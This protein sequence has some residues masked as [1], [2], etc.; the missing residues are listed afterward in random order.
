M[1]LQVRVCDVCGEVTRRTRRYEINREGDNLAVIV[2][3]CSRHASPLEAF[4]TRKDGEDEK[5]GAAATPKPTKTPRRPRRSGV[6][7][8]TLDEIEE[9]KRKSGG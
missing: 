9:G 2:D 7:A 5:V 4:L 8:T 6:K 3:L 1:E